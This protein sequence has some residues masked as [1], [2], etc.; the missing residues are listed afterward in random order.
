MKQWALQIDSHLHPGI[1]GRTAPRA[2]MGGARG[3]GPQRWVYVDNYHAA[4]AASRSQPMLAAVELSR[5]AM[6][7]LSYS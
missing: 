5:Y 4:D 6:V 7:L 2:G 3:Q 1:L